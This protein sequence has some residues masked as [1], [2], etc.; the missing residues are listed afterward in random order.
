MK[1]LGPGAT[2][3]SGTAEVPDRMGDCPIRRVVCPV[4]GAMGSH[5]RFRR[6]AETISLLRINV[7]MAVGVG[8]TGAGR[9]EGSSEGRDERR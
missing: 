8:E 5:G 4:L 9:L 2:G 6:E 3:L 1:K 7:V